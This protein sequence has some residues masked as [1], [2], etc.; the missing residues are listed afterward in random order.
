MATKYGL[1]LKNMIRNEY[2]CK[3][4]DVDS[5]KKIFEKLV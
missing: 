2:I 3:K 5:I 1:P 4:L